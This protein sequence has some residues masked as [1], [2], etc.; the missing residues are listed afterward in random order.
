MS[1]RGFTKNVSQLCCACNYER[2]SPSHLDEFGFF[3]RQGTNLTQHNPNKMETDDYLLSPHFRGE[4]RIAYKG[5]GK[6]KSYKEQLIKIPPSGLL[7]RD[8][9]E[10]IQ[11]Y[12]RQNFR[13]YYPNGDDEPT[14]EIKKLDLSAQ[15]SAQELETYNE[16]EVFVIALGYNQANRP[17]VNTVFGKEIV[18]NVEFYVVDTFKN[19]IKYLEK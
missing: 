3:Y 16:K 14:T 10:N 13:F 11:N 1:C 7:E 8:C 15:Y 19:L 18:G 12:A 17:E 6:E 5:G 2:G 4:I 9:Q